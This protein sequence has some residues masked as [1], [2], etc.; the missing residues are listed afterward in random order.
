MKRLFGVLFLLTVFV[1]SCSAI[2]LEQT[3]AVN[4]DTQATIDA[5]VQTAAEQT[6]AVQPSPTPA[7]PTPT[8]T[9]ASTASPLPLTVTASPTSAPSGTP[10]PNLTTTP[11]TATSGPS[12]TPTPAS[13]AK[14]TQTP[15]PG[16]LLYG[17]LPPAVPSAS[18]TIINKSKTPVYI[19]LQNYPPHRPAAFL[20]Y[21]VKRQVQVDAPLGYY[22]YVVWVD[23]KQIVGSFRLHNGDSL[24][25]VIFKDR[26]VIK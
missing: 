18:I 25:I 9:A 13:S 22:V 23:G 21:P 8:E 12:D 1:S 5:I 7:P 4:I 17:T 6:A 10:L 24:T 14:P 20:E 15:T 26:V 2:G 19:S 3:P 16:P 11:A